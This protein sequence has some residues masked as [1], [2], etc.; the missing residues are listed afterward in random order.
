MRLVDTGAETAR[1]SDLAIGGEIA[2]GREARRQARTA[3][4]A[5]TERAAAARGACSTDARAVGAWF[6][7][8]G[9]GGCVLV[10]AMPVTGSGEVGR[11]VHADTLTDVLCARAAGPRVANRTCEDARGRSTSMTHGCACEVGALPFSVVGELRVRFYRAGSVA[12]P[13][14]ATRIGVARRPPNERATSITGSRATDID[15]A[16]AGGARTCCE[17][18][19]DEQPGGYWQVTKPAHMPREFGFVGLL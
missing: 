18:E 3:L 17:C 6:A 10:V 9:L 16:I 7:H 5:S 13:G 11:E 8:A 4:A 14:R 15:T 1:L 12:L 19:R 2:A